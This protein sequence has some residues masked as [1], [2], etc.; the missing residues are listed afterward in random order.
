MSEKFTYK[1]RGVCS[2]SITFELEEGKLHNVRF[3][4]GCHGNTQ[5]LAALAEGMDASDLVKRLEGTDCR[6]RGTSCP[7][8]LA[9]AVKEALA[10]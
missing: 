8:Q 6:G 3:E 7:D 5:G 1:T 4:G 10:Q 2:R 9:K